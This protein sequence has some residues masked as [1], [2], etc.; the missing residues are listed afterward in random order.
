MMAPAIKGNNQDQIEGRF[1]WVIILGLR[2]YKIQIL[3][4][5]THIISLYTCS[6]LG[7]TSAFYIFISMKGPVQKIPKH[8]EAH[9]TRMLENSFG[10]LGQAEIKAILSLAQWQTIL[11]GQTLFKQ[12]DIAE[13]LFLLVHGKLKAVRYE[14]ERMQILGE[15]NSG[16]L[17]G[18]MA[19]ISERTRRINVEAVRDS[20]L[21]Y[22]SEKDFRSLYFSY[23][24]LGWNLSKLI[25]KRFEIEDLKRD[26]LKLKNIVV[27]P[28]IPDLGIQPIID[29]LDVQAS[30]RSIVVIKESE[31]QDN[32]TNYNQPGDPQTEA[33]SHASHMERSHD[34]VLYQGH[35]EDCAW[36]DFI[37]R[38]ADEIL[39]VTDGQNPIPV[40]W[41]KRLLR[42]KNKLVVTSLMVLHSSNPSESLPVRSLIH[43][44]PVNRIFHIRG[45]SNNDIGRWK[46]HLFDQGVG[47]VL[48]G[49]GARAMAHLGVYRA[50]KENNIP[51]DRV[52]GTSM[53]AL[54]GGLMALD[55]DPDEIYAVIKEICGSRPSRDFNPVPYSSVIRGKNLDRILMRYYG[56]K[57]IEDC[58]IPFACVSTNLTKAQADIHTYGDM[59]SAIRASG[60]LPGVVPPVPIQNSWHVD[61]G[62][63]D[64][65]PVD[66]MIRY[67]VNTIIGVSFESGNN[68]SARYSHI[69]TL[70]DQFLHGFLSRDETLRLP[71]IIE[72]VMLSSTAHSTSRQLSMEKKVDYLIQPKV[73]EIGLLEW[74]GFE[75]AVQQ[76]YEKASRILPSIRRT[77]ED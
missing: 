5:S 6:Y 22:L 60:S 42:K 33:I 40:N 3:V 2:S 10:S 24:Q 48:A 72:T 13:S 28:A 67:G 64:N 31:H 38:Q 8:M 18:E 65:F 75:R 29:E 17:I 57:N 77:W 62:I 73:S 61:G 21:I 43:E 76:G 41:A 51:I 34:L 27:L 70:K 25:L 39:I 36:N 14:N 58:P 54:V 49:G 53:G 23:P 52:N 7:N 4:C 66:E 44:H 30:S 59:F 69:P 46:R 9:V 16:E 15:I 1:S 12:G 50:L 32:F 35:T 55:K 63:V 11:G 45:Q 19:L 26:S 74:T 47:L 71:S 56:N 20:Q 68:P 37:I